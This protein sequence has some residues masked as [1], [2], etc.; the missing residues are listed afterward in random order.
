MD[1]FAAGGWGSLFVAEVGASA[2]LAGLLFVA[3]SINLARILQLPGLPGRGLE[4]LALLVTVLVASTLGLVPGQPPWAR[5]AELLGVGLVAWAV[6]LA[7]HV[8]ALRV[9]AGTSTGSRVVRVVV[10]QAAILPFPG[11]GL[12]LLLQAAGGL[13]WLAGGIILCFVVAV[14]DGWVLLVEV[15]R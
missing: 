12:A 14:I 13:Y 5:G 1:A 9:R 10:A 4:A 2:A 6:L 8:Q 3:I 15:L 11:A 7:I